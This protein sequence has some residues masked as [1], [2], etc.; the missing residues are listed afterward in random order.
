MQ[1][2]I[3]F[4]GRG[5]WSSK[6]DIESLNEKIEQLNNEGW[7]VKSMVPNTSFAGSVISYSLLLETHK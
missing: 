3:E 4:N 2:V 5:F 7:K 1:K 6:V